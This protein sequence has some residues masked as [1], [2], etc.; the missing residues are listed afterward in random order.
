MDRLSRRLKKFPCPI[1][2]RFPPCEQTLR[3]CLPP[4][5]VAA[6]KLTMLGFFRGLWAMQLDWEALCQAEK[7]CSSILVSLEFASRCLLLSCD[8]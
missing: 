4:A 8:L 2:G 3:P 7:T 5:Q 6:A 1:Q